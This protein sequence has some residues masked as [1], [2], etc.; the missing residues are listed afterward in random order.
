VLLKRVLLKRVL[1]K[2]VLLS[3]RRFLPLFS[4]TF[5]SEMP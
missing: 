1:L 5:I 2:R 3:P 4:A